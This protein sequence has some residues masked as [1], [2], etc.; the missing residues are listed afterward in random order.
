MSYVA[1]P[2]GK[3]RRCE[4]GGAW[5]LAMKPPSLLVGNGQGWYGKRIDAFRVGEQIVERLPK[6]AS[7]AEQ[8]ELFAFV[9]RTAEAVG[10]ADNYVAL[11]TE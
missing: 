7:G 8:E 5:S 2:Q 10:T 1:P 4:S 3:Q 6:L 9:V 11:Y